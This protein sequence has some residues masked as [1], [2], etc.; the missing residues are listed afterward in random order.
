MD[1]H[2]ILLI[3]PSMKTNLIFKEINENIRSIILL[4]A[5]FNFS[6]CNSQ[7]IKDN[8]KLSISPQKSFNSLMNYCDTHLDQLSSDSLIYYVDSIYRYTY[9]IDTTGTECLNLMIRL[10]KKSLSINQ[11]SL[12]AAEKLG[13]L[14]LSNKEYQKALEILN[15]YFNDTSD[16]IHLMSKSEIYLKLGNREM[17]NIGFDIVKRKCE[18]ILQNNPNLKKDSFLGYTY[19][20]SIIAFVQEGKM[21]ALTRM[22]LAK[23]KYPDDPFVNGLYDNFEGFMNEEELINHYLP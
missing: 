15:K 7:V 3:E 4:L 6:S 22:N 5:I 12:L 14:Y 19:M 8:S 20:L 10:S 17:A 1:Q 16:V 2:L 13:S 23:T 11:T 18:R 9:R 21:A